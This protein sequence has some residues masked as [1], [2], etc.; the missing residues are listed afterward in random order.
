MCSLSSKFL[1]LEE[2]QDRIT[3]RTERKRQF[4]AH[5]ASIFRISYQLADGS[6]EPGLSHAHHCTEDPKAECYT[7]SCSRGK[8]GSGA[9]VGQVVSKEGALKDKVLCERDSFVDC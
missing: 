2:S 3:S 8:A 6:D 9:V 5:V 7:S 1:L 4:E